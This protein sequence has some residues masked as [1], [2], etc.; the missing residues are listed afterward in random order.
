MDQVVLPGGGA[1]VGVL[2]GS[3]LRSQTYSILTDHG[4][5][6]PVATQKHVTKLG[7][8]TGAAVPVPANLLAL[9]RTGP[10]LTSEAVLRPVPAI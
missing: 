6:Y 8:S 5:R 2:A 9:F 7:Y 1:F 3:G 4:I 10:A